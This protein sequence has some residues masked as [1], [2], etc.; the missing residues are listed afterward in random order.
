[1]SSDPIC[2][3]THTDLKSI[4]NTFNTA[5]VSHLL[6]TD[7]K[8]Q[9]AG[10][11]SKN[12]LLEEFAALL[13]QTSGQ[14]YTGLE[15]KTKTAATIMTEKPMVVNKSSTIDLAIEYLL[16]KSFHCVPVIEDG[17]PIGIL[18]A[19]DLLKGYYQEYG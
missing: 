1:M 12:D 5:K 18:T 8:G 11:I 7:D 13:Q 2:V 14:A 6:V 16:Q 3:Y 9:L 4:I 10:V 15:L 19:F 17:K